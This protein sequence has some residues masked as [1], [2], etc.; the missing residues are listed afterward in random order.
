[1]VY[2]STVATVMRMHNLRVLDDNVVSYSKE[3]S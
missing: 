3:T 1:M 2:P